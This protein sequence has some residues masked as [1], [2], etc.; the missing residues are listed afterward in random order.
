MNWKP[1]S[2]ELDSGVVTVRSEVK[3]ETLLRILNDPQKSETMRKLGWNI[4]AARIEC[5]KVIA[6]KKP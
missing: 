1:K 5:E 4:E 6:G 2:V 3:A